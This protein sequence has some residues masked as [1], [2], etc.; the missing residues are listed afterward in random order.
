MRAK[1]GTLNYLG[2]ICEQFAG[3]AQAFQRRLFFTLYRDAVISDLHGQSFLGRK[4]LY[5]HLL[6]KIGA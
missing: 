2:M 5:R 1:R 6:S 4:G 3:I